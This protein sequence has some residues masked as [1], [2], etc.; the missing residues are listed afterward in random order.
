MDRVEWL[1]RSLRVL[2][3][4]YGKPIEV[5]FAV[6]E[7]ERC[8]LQVGHTND[9]NIIGIGDD[10]P[11]AVEAGIHKFTDE[12]L[13]AAEG[14]T[15]RSLVTSAVMTR[16]GHPDAA[17]EEQV[18]LKLNGFARKVHALVQEA[19]DLETEYAGVCLGYGLGALMA[20]GATEAQLRERCEE[21]IQGLADGAAAIVAHEKKTFS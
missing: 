17:P 20:L 6:G 13:L 21:A 15:R 1:D 9:F 7:N 4:H 8:W 3:K 2:S 16:M 19:G 10:L 12:Q 14:E 11:G 5:N 18:A